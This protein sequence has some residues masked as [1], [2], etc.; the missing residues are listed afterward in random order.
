MRWVKVLPPEALA[1][2]LAPRLPLLAGGG[3]DLPDRQQTMRDT[4]AWSYELLQPDEQ[5]LFR[6]LGVFAGG[7]TLEAVEAI[8]G[9]DCS[10]A[11]LTLVAALVDKSL[12]RPMPAVASET[13]PGS[14]C[15][16]RSESLPWS[17]SRPAAR[18]RRSAWRTRAIA[19]TWSRRCA[20]AAGAQKGR[21]D[22]LQAEHAN[23]RATLEWLDA[24]GPVVDFVHLAALLPGFWS[25]GG[26][27]REGRTWLERAWQRP[28][29]LPLMTEPASRSGWALC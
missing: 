13:G 17:G 16:R 28:R 6:R 2:R 21:L 11:T 20:D 24:K 22:Q 18:S 25:R 15:W 23:V 10:P 27:L 26:H 4:I 3:G 7:F 29:R 1:E 12:V 14:G 5:R 8:G 19:R 9:D